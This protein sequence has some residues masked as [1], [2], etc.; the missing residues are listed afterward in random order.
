MAEVIDRCPTGI[1]GFDKI[2]NGGFVR[3]SDNLIIGGPGSGKT[4]FL[5][6]FL[7]NG[8][9]RFNENG[10]YCSFEPDIIETL[11]DAMSHG[12][13]FTR[14]SSEGRVKFMR[15]SPQTSIDD[16]KSEIIKMVSKNNIR[17]VC[18]DPISVL[19]LGLDKPWKI[20]EKIFELSSLMKRM[21]VTVL[22][23]DESMEGEGLE[24]QM[25]GEWTKTDI[26]RFLA[27]SV[28]LFYDYGIDGETDRSLRIIKM[29]RT[30]HVR[31]A[32][33]M[34]LTDE[35]IFVKHIGVEEI[36]P[37][38]FD[39]NPIFTNIKQQPSVEW[40]EPVVPKVESIEARTAYNQSPNTE[41][42]EGINQ[43]FTGPIE[44]PKSPATQ[45]VAPTYA[46]QPSLIPERRAEV[47]MNPQLQKPIE[48]KKVGMSIVNGEEEH[49]EELWR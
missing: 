12:W 5:L 45:M 28:T 7:Y 36:E 26:L 35:G 39:N 20:R 38:F 43:N 16:L 48:S 30:N 1:K 34:S 2:C 42:S 9:T 22:Y 18:F 23:A 29:R 14:L 8:A 31:E 25:E 15:F 27:D 6:E 11:N 44:V 21:K 32:V 41:V 3:D 40:N 46:P 10:L 49:E 47:P 17:R 33:G 37:K 13:D 4:T 19:A 24:R